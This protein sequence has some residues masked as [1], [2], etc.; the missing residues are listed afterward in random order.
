VYSVYAF[1]LGFVRGGFVKIIYIYPSKRWKYL[2]ARRYLEEVALKGKNLD[3]IVDDIR[4]LI[5]QYLLTLPVD[6]DVE[7]RTD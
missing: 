2:M 5:A 1:L 3:E 7:C 4:N 6:S